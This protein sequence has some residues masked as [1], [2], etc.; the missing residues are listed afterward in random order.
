M[1]ALEQQCHGFTPIDSSAIASALA[2]IRKG[3]E[4]YALRQQYL[5]MMPK[6]DVTATKEELTADLQR[7]REATS[8]SIG[9]LYDQ[10]LSLCLRLIQ[11]VYPQWR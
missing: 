9:I 2:K 11:V 4:H 6:V 7:Y 3:R 8:Y 1:K 5:S 10:F